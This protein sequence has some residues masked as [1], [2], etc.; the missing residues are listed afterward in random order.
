MAT[1]TVD[2]LTSKIVEDLASGLT[3]LKR[4]DNGFGSIQEKYGATD[5]QIQ[6]IRKHPKLKDLQPSTIIFNLIDD[7]DDENPIAGSTV[8]TAQESAAGRTSE[9]GPARTQVAVETQHQTVGVTASNEDVN[10]FLNI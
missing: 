4:D 3:W 10:A 2:I 1:Q 7:L 6:L 9:E 8:P 5:L